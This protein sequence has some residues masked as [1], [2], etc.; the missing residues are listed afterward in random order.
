M[1]QKRLSLA[2]GPYPSIFGQSG[3][4]VPNSNWNFTPTHSTRR[5]SDN[6]VQQTDGLTIDSP[7]MLGATT[8]FLSQNKLQ[9]NVEDKIDENMVGFFVSALLIPL[10]HHSPVKTIERVADVE[11]PSNSPPI[12]SLSTDTQLR[13]QPISSASQQ[14]EP[15]NVA[16]SQPR[17]TTPPEFPIH[18]HAEHDDPDQLLPSPSAMLVSPVSSPSS[19]IVNARKQRFTMGPRADCEKCRLGVKGHWMHFD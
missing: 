16:L 9:T 3:F 11:P 14:L 15:K 13:V 5:C 8:A 7:P 17:S 6:W 12:L 19:A 4:R 2:T 1:V 10:T 18:C